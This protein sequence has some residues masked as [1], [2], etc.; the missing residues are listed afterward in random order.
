MAI[1]LCRCPVP[2]I[3]FLETLATPEGEKSK[4]GQKHQARNCGRPTCLLK[5]MEG[6]K[7]WLRFSNP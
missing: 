5:S 6:G 7:S 1:Y 2:G 3:G 4:L